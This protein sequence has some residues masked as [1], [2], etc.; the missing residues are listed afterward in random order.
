MN[1]SF[2]VIDGLVHASAGLSL[3]AAKWYCR[4]HAIPRLGRMLSMQAY[5]LLHHG[6]PRGCDDYVRQR[7]HVDAAGG[8]SF[9]CALDLLE[10]Q[11]YLKA[12][13]TEVRSLMRG[14]VYLGARLGRPSPQPSLP[15][16][17][18]SNCPSLM[19][20]RYVIQGSSLRAP[21]RACWR[22]ASKRLPGGCEGS[23]RVG[24]RAT[25]AIG[26]TAC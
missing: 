4:A 15:P 2:S 1:L 24:T 21:I 14:K 19:S 5:H 10:E 18:G 3:C 8:P 17:L 26:V 23:S 9:S 7:R 16:G 13:M 22:S 20:Q 11:S 12:V 25:R 6:L